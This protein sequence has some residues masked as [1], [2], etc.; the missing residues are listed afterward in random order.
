MTT[1]KKVG[2]VF[3]VIGIFL[4]FLVRSLNGGDTLVFA[5][6]N[7]FMTYFVV[8]MLSWILI[9]LGTILLLWERLIRK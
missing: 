4:G 8:K 1:G 6:R 9:L 7:V 3:V 2:I 5:P